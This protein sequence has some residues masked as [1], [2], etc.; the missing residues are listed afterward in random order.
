MAVL[1]L[2]FILIQLDKLGYAI[3][4]VNDDNSHWAASVDGL[5]NISGTNEIID[6]SMMVFIESNKWKN[7]PKEAIVTFLR[8]LY[9]EIDEID[10]IDKTNEDDDI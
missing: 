8:S 2:D 6:I 10:E 5:Q 1:P 9:D 4:L 7:T 3:N